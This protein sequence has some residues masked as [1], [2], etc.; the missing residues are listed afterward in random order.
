MAV[1][2]WGL[3]KPETGK[4]FEDYPPVNDPLARSE[5]RHGQILFPRPS[6][7]S[8]ASSDTRPKSL[9]GR[10]TCR[11]VSLRRGSQ[12]KLPQ[13]VPE[14]KSVARVEGISVYAPAIDPDDPCS[15]IL[16]FLRPAAQNFKVVSRAVF[17][18][19][20]AS[21]GRAGCGDGP[22]KEGQRVVYAGSTHSTPRLTR[23]AFSCPWACST[24]GSAGTSPFLCMRLV[25]YMKR[26][27]RE[28]PPQ[29]RR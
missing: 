14:L 6:G 5:F 8:S 19:H 18:A 28:S 3:P 10:D 4:Y 15:E 20:T 29:T 16:S 7:G 26:P 27:Q 12:P 1:P 25:C 13:C 24:A 23:V 9:A 17:A 2:R 21:R 22:C 11:L